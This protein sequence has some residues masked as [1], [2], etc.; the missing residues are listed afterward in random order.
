MDKQHERAD[1]WWIRLGWLVWIWAAS[2]GALAVAAFL[3]KALMRAAGM[4][5]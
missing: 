3:M 4:S 1:N 2:V 5:N